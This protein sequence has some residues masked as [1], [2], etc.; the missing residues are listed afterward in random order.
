M[1]KTS[2]AYKKLYHYTNWDG[3]YG[4]IQNQTL[5]ATHC[6]FL[7]DYSEIELFRSKLIEFLLPHVLQKCN[8]LIT[9][10][11]HETKVFVDAMYKATGYEFYT[12]SFC[13]EHKT[14]EY[15]NT[16]GLLSQWRGYGKDG[17]FALVFDTKKLEKI[18][19][20]EGKR[21]TNWELILTDCLYDDEKLKSELSEPMNN[22]AD[23][24]KE[25]IETNKP[26]DA[27]KAYNA[28]VQCAS[29]YKHQ[30][31]KEENE[32]RIVG[33]LP[34]QNKKE[35]K[36]RAKDG[37][38]IP[39]IELFNLQDITLPIERIIVGPHKEKEDRARALDLMLKH[40]FKMEGIKV[41]ISDIP[42]I[43]N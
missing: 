26:P 22:I 28:F 33:Y 38:Q 27:G 37:S 25:G 36:F 31:F 1:R 19:Q 4:I 41:A 11:E 12:V 14:D 9:D 6:K 18:L 34:S 32:V 23:F 3:L 35:R 21:Y 40:K 42:Y 8:G 43:G 7:N 5:W 20:H 10:A 16:N 13:G 30:G 39:Y 15:I 24:L 17:G 2:E 29:R